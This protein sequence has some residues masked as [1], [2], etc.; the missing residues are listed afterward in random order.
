MRLHGDIQLCYCLNNL[1]SSELGLE[2]PRFIG[3]MNKVRK[4]ADETYLHQTRAFEKNGDIHRYPDIPVALRE[5]NRSLPWLI[6]YHVPI[7]LDNLPGG[8]T[9]EK[10]EIEHILEL[11]KNRCIKCNQIEIETY[12]FPVLPESVK[13]ISISRGINGSGISVYFVKTTINVKVQQN[14]FC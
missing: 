3:M 5:A 4:L 9:A 7:Y 12:T 2:K 6:H 13:K 1:D 8:L 14:I 10:S 11:L